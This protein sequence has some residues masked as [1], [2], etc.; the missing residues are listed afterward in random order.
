MFSFTD[1]VRKVFWTFPFAFCYQ[2]EE[3]RNKKKKENFYRMA[4]S[5]LWRK[6]HCSVSL[7]SWRALSGSIHWHSNERKI[8]YF[9]CARHEL[10]AIASYHSGFGFAKLVHHRFSFGLVMLEQWHSDFSF[11]SESRRWC[12]KFIFASYRGRREKVSFAFVVAVTEE[13]FARPLSP[14]W[15]G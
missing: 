13:M 9:I 12:Q 10:H 7:I 14:S 8:K 3:K 2:H 5:G 1:A 6:K 4:S 11:L 15:Q